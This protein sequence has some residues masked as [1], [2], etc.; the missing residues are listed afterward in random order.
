[1]KELPLLT[2]AI[3]T[4]NRAEILD[5]L[6]ENITTDPRY[7]IGTVEILVS[8]NASTDHTS[9]IVAKYSSVNYFRNDKNIGFENFTVAL[10]LSSGVYIHLLNDTAR[11]LPG[12]LGLMLDEIEKSNPKEVNLLFVNE[13]LNYKKGFLVLS[14]KDQLINA[15]SFQITWIANFGIW[16]SD[17]KKLKDKDRF[18]NSLMQH[19]DWILSMID[20]NKPTKVIIDKFVEIESVK[21]KGKYNIFDTFINKYTLILKFHNIGYF[22]YKIEKYRLFRYFILHWFFLLRND[23]EYSFDTSQSSIIL[24]KYWYEPYFLPLIILKL[25]IH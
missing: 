18:C 9:E 23:D 16:S 2:L 12:M 19:V 11:L 24:Q 5:K 25:L 3:P 20:N 21:N 14:T 1:M 17:F 10:N 13:L 22:Y 8:D 6:L 7:S 4:Y 15:L